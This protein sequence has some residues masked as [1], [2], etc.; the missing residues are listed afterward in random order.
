M[1]LPKDPNWFRREATLGRYVSALDGGDL[2]AVEAVLT[3]AMDD[4]EL[5]AA[6]DAVH[7]AYQ[8]EMQLGPAAQDVALVRELVRKHFQSAFADD[9]AVFG[10][11]EPLTVHDVALEL[12][13]TRRV[14]AADRSANAQLLHNRQ[15]VP[16]Q[17]SLQAVKQLAQEVGVQASE[18]FWKLFRDTAIML[19][20]GRSH[21]Q[22]L[23]AAREEGRLTPG[24]EETASGGHH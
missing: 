18:R 19:G 22:A 17:L 2:E 10:Q 11:E 21:Q 1:P 20:I 8:E 7:L 4:P 12:E 15:P 14:P 3:A 13:Y 24:G 9:Q 16:A 5:A 6:L 23:S